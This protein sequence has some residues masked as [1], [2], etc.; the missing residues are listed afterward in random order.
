MPAIADDRE[1]ALAVLQATIEA[2]DPPVNGHIAVDVW[3]VGHETMQQLAFID[4][5]VP[6]GDMYD[7]RLMLPS[8]D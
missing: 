3:E 6:V 4:G 1:T 5:S 2:W 8:F 7:L